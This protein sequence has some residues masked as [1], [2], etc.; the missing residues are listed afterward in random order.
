[1]NAVCVELGLFDGHFLHCQAR[2]RSRDLLG[3]RAGYG[4]GQGGIGGL[5][6]GASLRELF[7]ARPLFELLQVGL[8]L[9][10]QRSGLHQLGG[11]IAR[12]EREQRL[13][14]LHGIAFTDQDVLDAT[15]SP[16]TDGDRA[17]LDRAA[18]LIG[19]ALEVNAV[20]PVAQRQ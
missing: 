9:N 20:A 13:T 2:L 19:L 4:L 3:P 10:Q 14:A 11:I 12:L 6:A 7:R 17:R 15:A 1:M 18:P 5:R 16:R 8:P